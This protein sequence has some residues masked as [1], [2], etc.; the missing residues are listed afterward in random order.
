[1]NIVY[2]IAAIL[3]AVLLLCAAATRIGVAIIDRNNPPTGSFLTVDG[4]L[5]HYMHVAAPPQPHGPALVFLHGAS[6]NLNDQ[7][8]VLRT[9]FEGRHEMLFLDRPGHGWSGPQPGGNGHID[10]QSD[11]VAKLLS[12]LGIGKAIIIGHSF[13]GAVATTF[14]VRHPDQT[15]GLLLLAAATH[16]WP[17]GGTSW[18]NDLTAIPVV[19]RVFSETLALTAGWSRIGPATDCVFA[20]NQAP[21]GYVDAAQIKLVLRPANF[22]AN[23]L[24]VKSL[25]GHVKAFA[26]RYGEITAPTIVVSGDRDTVVYEEIHSVGLARDIPG[27]EL[28]WLRNVGHKPDYVAR[29]LL[30]DAVAKLSGGTVDLQAAAQRVEARVANDNFGPVDRCGDMP[31]PVPAE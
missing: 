29:D 22:R 18:Y 13:G 2:A 6:G 24:D 30:V 8:T 3:A 7:M 5:F 17:G 14:A 28:V 4:A 9:L 23:A 12:E 26:P 10:I 27:A 16:P 25:Y 1:M 15:A 19:G 21:A 11:Y 31:A 20:P